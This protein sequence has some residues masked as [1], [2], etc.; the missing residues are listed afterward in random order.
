MNLT[1]ANTVIAAV[2]AVVNSLFPFLIVIGVLN[3]TGEQTAA[4]ILVISNLVTLGGLFLASTPV[5]NA[6]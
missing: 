2:M 6:P 5:T 3:W 4:C 1:R